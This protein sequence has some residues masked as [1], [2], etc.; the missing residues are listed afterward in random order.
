M[1][2]RFQKLAK[3]IKVFFQDDN[4]LD[5]LHHLENI[6]SKILSVA[7]VVVIL[8]ALFDLIVVLS[9]DLF[10][11]EPLGFFGKTLI[12]IFGLFL[13]ILI[14]LE[15]LENITAYLKKHIV[16]VELV[17]VTALI[18]VARKIIIFDPQKYDKIDLIA[19]AIASLALAVSYWLIRLSNK[20]S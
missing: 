9:K 19:L 4:F 18:A 14:A 20:K 15:L 1:I 11:T 17:V 12:E 6:V 7:L 3:N 13:N 16:Q 10:T 8:V 5:S 2:L